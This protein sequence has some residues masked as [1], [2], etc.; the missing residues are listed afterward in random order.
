[1]FNLKISPRFADTDALG[2]INN[3]ALITW[4]EEARRPIFK[5]FI[6]DLD[7][8]KWKLILAHFRVDFKA[9]TYYQKDAEIKTTIS[10]IG[11][12]SFELSQE[13]WQGETLCATALVIMVHFDYTKNK[14]ASIP[15]QIK[16]KLE[17]HQN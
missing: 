15:K 7:P 14:S 9:Q 5:I 10:K 6:P 2:H 13:V 12:S 16:E 11:N 17:T 1:M 8:K 3:A 4:L